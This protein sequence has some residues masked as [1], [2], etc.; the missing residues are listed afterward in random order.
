MSNFI[1]NCVYFTE[2]EEY[3]IDIGL[4]QY[5]DYTPSVRINH[6]KDGNY[7]IP[8]SVILNEADWYKLISFSEKITNFL[9]NTT[10]TTAESKNLE[11]K[12]TTTEEVD[13]GNYT[14]E[15][16][17][18]EV[19]LKFKFKMFASFPL[20]LPCL[21]I[22][23]LLWSEILRL[24]TCIAYKF[25]LIDNYKFYGKLIH[26][27]IVNYF[28]N[29]ISK[30]EID[31]DQLTL[32]T[33]KGLLIGLKSNVLPKSPIECNYDFFN[34]DICLTIDAEIRANSVCII[35]NDI[36]NALVKFSQMSYTNSNQWW[37]W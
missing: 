24:H 28:L 31:K 20:S 33:L 9:S 7:D 13:I 35:F 16:N 5:N 30:N 29:L 25:K 26:A 32:Q 8:E 18:H 23:S 34:R 6:V 27:K 37:W 12:Y 2:N 1:L 10:Q 19:S 15:F 22:N 17:Y 36:N 3:Y 4:H 14:L 21:E 11:S